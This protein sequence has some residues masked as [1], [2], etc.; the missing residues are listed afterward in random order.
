[1]YITYYV[2]WKNIF[3]IIYS[4]QWSDI[5]NEKNYCIRYYVGIVLKAYL[6]EYYFY[7][8]IDYLSIVLRKHIQNGHQLSSSVRQNHVFCLRPNLP[9]KLFCSCRIFF[10]FLKIKKIHILYFK[11][12]F[13][14]INHKMSLMDNFMSI[15]R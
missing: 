15:L 11:Q 6:H 13:D 14:S 5:T 12:L 9:R 2:I 8:R 10:L 1:M 3:N 4:F 7:S